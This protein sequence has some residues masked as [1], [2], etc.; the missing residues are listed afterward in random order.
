MN[1]LSY[2]AVVFVAALAVASASPQYVVCP[3]NKCQ[4]GFDCVDC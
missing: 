4:K 1:F 2:V 3:G